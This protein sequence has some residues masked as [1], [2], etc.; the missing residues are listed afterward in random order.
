MIKAAELLIRTNKDIKQI[1][2]S[3]A[4]KNPSK[5]TWALGSFP[6]VTP[7]NYIKDILRRKKLFTYLQ[8]IFFLLLTFNIWCKDFGCRN[9]TIN[10]SA[11]R[12]MVER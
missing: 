11:F 6:C 4:F 1:A 7:G 12:K 5:F 9:D 8:I 3:T 2:I 10:E